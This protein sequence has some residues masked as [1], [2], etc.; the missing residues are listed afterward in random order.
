MTREQLI[1]R[2]TS[3]G[4]TLETSR[5]DLAK[6]EGGMEQVI[7][8]LKQSI[9]LNSIEEAATRI[10]L[11]TE[12]IKVKEEEVTALHDKISSIYNW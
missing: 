5:S 12:Q 8:H 6:Y 7:A 2:F 11:L 3:L 1:E 4:K 10:Q 9:G